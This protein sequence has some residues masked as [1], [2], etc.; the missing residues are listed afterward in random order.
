M[1]AESVRAMVQSLDA[2]GALPPKPSGH[3]DILDNVDVAIDPHQ[4]IHAMVHMLRGTAQVFQRIGIGALRNTTGIPFLTSDNPVIWF[5]PSVSDSEMLPYTLK[6]NGPVALLFPIA[7]NLMIYG[8]SSM[9]ARFASEGFG[10][11]DLS[12]TH[13]V[14]MMNRQIC[15]FAYHAVFAQMPGQESL[16]R[17]FVEMSPVL[18]TR[19]VPKSHGK[20]LVF[21]QVFGKRQPKLKW[22]REPSS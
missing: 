21:Q 20:L 10:Y 3:E 1:Y 13:S 16:I 19:V 4:S 9:R 14:R 15:R 11:G 17:E 5:D 7:P 2:A 8:D 12:D 22:P 6:Q 18:E